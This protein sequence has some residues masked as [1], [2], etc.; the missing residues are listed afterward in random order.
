[1][2]IQG[3]RMPIADVVRMGYG[4]HTRDSQQREPQ[5]QRKFPGCDRSDGVIAPMQA[6]TGACRVL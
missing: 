5:P 2:G 6:M 4:D 1:M 3:G